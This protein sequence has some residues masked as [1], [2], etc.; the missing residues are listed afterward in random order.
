MVIS[1]KKMVIHIK[2]FGKILKQKDGVYINQTMVHVM[3]ANGLKI[4]KMDLVL[5]NGQEAVYILEIMLTDIK[6]V[7]G[8]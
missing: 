4:Y 3:M 2:V 6:M 5:S 7:L 1:G 8:C